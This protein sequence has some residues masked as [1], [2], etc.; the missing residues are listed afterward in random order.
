MKTKPTYFTGEKA[1]TRDEYTKLLS[2]TENQEQKVLLMLGAGLGLR[3]F[4]MSRIIVRNIDFKNHTLIYLEKKKRDA[5]HTVHIPP[6]LEHELEIYINERKLGLNDR[7]FS[8][9]DRQL[10]NWYYYLLDKAGI[11]K[12]G[13]HSLRGT[14]VKFCQAAGWSIEQTA[15]LIND[16]VSTVQ[17]H[18]STPSQSEMKEITNNKEII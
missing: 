10:C 17:E 4:D 12:R 13:I 8:V 3:R 9:R 14:C 11:E 15:K 18:Y 5:P 16:K 6:K 7:L 2:V 1:L